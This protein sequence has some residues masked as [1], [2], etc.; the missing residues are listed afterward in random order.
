D[1]A[2]LWTSGASAARRV[3][4]GAQSL[5]FTPGGSLVTGG[6]DGRVSI[7]RA[8]DGSASP[9]RLLGRLGPAGVE[10]IAASRRLV[11]AAGAGGLALWSISGSAR[12]RPLPR[13][14]GGLEDLL[15]TDEH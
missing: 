2:R 4:M 13:H 6:S 10:S 3:A 1:E 9:S 5:A 14:F 12:K 11:A 15:P 7:R 8:G